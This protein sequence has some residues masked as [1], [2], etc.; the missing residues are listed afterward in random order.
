MPEFIG[1]EEA[2]LDGGLLEGQWGVGGEGR[3][4]RG[5]LGVF[6]TAFEWIF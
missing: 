3:G 1:H 6:S 2:G 5:N 4:V